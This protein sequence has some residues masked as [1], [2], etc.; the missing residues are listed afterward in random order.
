MEGDQGSDGFSSHALLLHIPLC[1][2]CLFFLGL[3]VHVAPHAKMFIRRYARRHR[4]CG[5]LY[6]AWLIT[7]LLDLANTAVQQ[8]H[9]NQPHSPLFYFAYDV[10]L[11]ALGIALTLSAAYDFSSHSRIKNPGVLI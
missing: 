2:Y 8:D 9:Y 6:L 3:F 7:G 11:G 4:V 5:L 10:I 1:L